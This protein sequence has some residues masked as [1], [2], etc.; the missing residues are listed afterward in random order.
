MPLTQSHNLEAVSV[1]ELVS[2][3]RDVYIPC[4]LTN[5]VE[6]GLVQRVSAARGVVTVHL[7][8]ACPYHDRWIRISRDIVDVLGALENVKRIEITM[9]P[10]KT[11]AR[12]LRSNTR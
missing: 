3:L 11:R 9:M 8:A 7:M 12:E 4:T 1:E 5:I 6:A 2:R 10:M